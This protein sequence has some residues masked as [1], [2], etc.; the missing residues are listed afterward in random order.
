MGG[1]GVG[2]V[3]IFTLLFVVNVAAVINL[4]LGGGRGG[5]RGNSTRGVGSGGSV[6]RGGVRGDATGA[7]T[8]L[9]AGNH[10]G[11]NECERKA[12]AN[13]FLHLFMFFN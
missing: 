10:H 2:T 3:E 5:C 7:D 1:G 13:N 12:K 6:R 11:C 9:V 4:L 8:L